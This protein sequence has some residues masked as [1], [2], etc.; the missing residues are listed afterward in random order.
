MHYVHANPNRPNSEYI[1]RSWHDQA[2]G[3][4]LGVRRPCILRRVLPF[5]KAADEIEK[6]TPVLDVGF[7]R[8]SRG[9][10]D[11]SED[12]GCV[13]FERRAGVTSFGNQ[14]LQRAGEPLGG[15]RCGPMLVDD[16]ARRGFERRRQRR[17]RIRDVEIDQRL[18]LRRS[19]SHEKAGQREEEL[20]L[21][22]VEVPRSVEERADV[23]LL[24]SNDNGRRMLAR[25]HQVR[26]VGATLNF[27]ETLRAA[28]DRANLVT[29]G[30]TRPPR[31]A[32]R[33]QGTD[34]IRS[35][36]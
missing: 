36:V 19:I 2:R 18:Q 26:A 1:R 13:P 31:F 9:I 25:R 14:R 3:L 28:A 30:G 20:R 23:T 15:Q 27:D 17:G 4:C 10:F 35:I 33:A 8:A 21:T 16:P 34:H 5:D 24:L 6:R 12:D 22:F 11:A 29:E 7:A 32:A